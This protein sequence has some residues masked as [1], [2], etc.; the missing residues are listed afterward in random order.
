VPHKPKIHDP[1]PGTRARTDV[2]PT[3]CRRGY[4]Y[5]WQRFRAAFLGLNPLCV[6]CLAEQK[7]V[8]ATDVDHD[9]PLTGPD[10]PGRL[11]PARC[12]ALCHSHHSRKTASEGRGS[13][14]SKADW[15]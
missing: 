8:P 2:R 6:A 14:F 4:D 3:S 15:A 13:R 1:F 11:D 5:K 9:Q 12:R 10:D 7:T